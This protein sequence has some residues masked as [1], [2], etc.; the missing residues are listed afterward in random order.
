MSTQ[1]SRTIRTDLPRSGSLRRDILLLETFYG[2]SRV[3]WDA[4]SKWLRVN[5]W[6]LPRGRYSFSCRSTDVLLM[7][8]EGYGELSGSDVG[9]EEFYIRP[10][11]RLLRAGEWVEMP[12][13]FT[14]MDRRSGEALRQGWRYLCVHTTWDARRDNVMT[15]MT[16]LGL[17]F[18]DPWAFER[19]AAANGGRHE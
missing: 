2:P 9:L 6:L 12:H 1:R 13:S 8:P 18:S 5:G 3:F 14:H 19:L 4:R 7:V 17:L 15:A 16:Q 10:D 11:L